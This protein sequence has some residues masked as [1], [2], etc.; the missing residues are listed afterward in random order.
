M[1]SLPIQLIYVS[2]SEN[3]SFR[4]SLQLLL[5]QRFDDS[6]VEKSAYSKALQWWLRWL[7]FI[8]GVL[9]QVMRLASFKNTPWTKI[10]GFIFLAHF[11][12]GEVLI[13]LSSWMPVPTFAPFPKEDDESKLHAW[14]SG[15]AMFGSLSFPAFIALQQLLISINGTGGVVLML[16]LFLYAILLPTFLV[17]G[18][19][20]VFA[21]CSG[22]EK[23]TKLIAGRY[24]DVVRGLMLAV[25][26]D[27]GVL[28]ADEEAVWFLGL[29]VINLVYCVLGYRFVYDPSGTVDPG[30]GGIFS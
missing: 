8:I 20:C 19:L 9:P 21:V 26:T 24:P 5:R 6:S 14:S 17:Y 13:L 12:V 22:L 4:T 16:S 1:F 10:I 7:F 27:N 29:L 30:W 2:F 25:E 18:L 3:I 28:T 11:L 15:V 23:T